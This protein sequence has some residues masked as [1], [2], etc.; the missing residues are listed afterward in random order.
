MAWKWSGSAYGSWGWVTSFT[1]LVS[2]SLTFRV[3]HLNCS[4]AGIF[5]NVCCQIWCCISN[6]CHWQNTAKVSVSRSCWFKCKRSC[7]L[8]CAWLQSEIAFGSQPFHYCFLIQWIAI[9]SRVSFSNCRSATSWVTGWKW[10]ELDDRMLVEARPPCLYMLLFLSTLHFCSFS[11]ACIVSCDDTAVNAYL[12]LIEMN[13]DEW[14]NQI[15]CPLIQA[16]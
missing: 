16:C 1:C 9:Y 13:A 10:K 7:C 8:K 5:L 14:R 12:R 2:W 15:F 3:F 11:A 4:I 6:R